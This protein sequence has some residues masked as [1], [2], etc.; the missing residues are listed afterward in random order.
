MK[1]ILLSTAV[2][3]TS[4]AF[5][6]ITL[7]HTFPVNE[8]VFA[9]AKGTEMMYV[10]Q[11]GNQL[12]I[13]NSVFALTNTVS[14]AVPPNYQLSFW[15]DSEEES[16]SIS[17]HI[18]NTDD[19]F[20]FVVTASNNSGPTSQ[21]KLMVVNENGVIVKDFH[22]T[23]NYG[24]EWEV[25]HDATTN[26]NKILIETWSGGNSQTPFNEVY[27]LPTSALTLK[28]IKGNKNLSAFPIPT[29]KILNVINPQ[30]G[31]NKIQIFDTSGK[32]VINKSFGNSDNKI[33]IDVEN[34]SKGVYIYK[35]GDLSSKF[36][37]N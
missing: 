5:G 4:L 19:L 26:T 22:P 20:E 9:F 27:G 31:A 21:R 35:I 37:K 6:Q 2:L 8:R 12:K 33:E 10:S 25:F 32:M 34:L 7:E 3:M 17:K 24:E 1:K 11:V 18:F 13:Y 36:I 15:Y 29:N 28:E 23:S 14:V 16:Y 30:N